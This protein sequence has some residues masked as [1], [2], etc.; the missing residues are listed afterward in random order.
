MCPGCLLTTTYC[1]PQDCCSA[2]QVMP[3]SYD[4]SYARF[5]RLKPWMYVAAD[6]SENV[7]VPLQ[8]G[9]VWEPFGR[10]AT[11]KARGVFFFIL[12]GDPSLLSSPFARNRAYSRR[13]E[14]LF[15]RRQ[16]TECKNQNS[17]AFENRARTGTGNIHPGLQQHLQ[18]TVLIQ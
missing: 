17:C 11:S 2:D 10:T 7:P 9:Q 1:A 14:G 15:S 4:L 6:K 8:H 12:G 16:N 18:S 13:M 3:A 5:L